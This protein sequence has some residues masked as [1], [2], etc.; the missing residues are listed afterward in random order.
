MDPLDRRVLVLNRLWQPV[1]ICGCRRAVGL[2]FLGHAEVVDVDDG[3]RFST[4]AIDSWIERSRGWRGT[5]V[6]HSVAVSLRS[7]AIIVLASYDRLPKQEI[8]FSRRN[9][10]ERDGYRCQYCGERFEPRDLNLDH[11]VP[12]DKGGGTSWENVVCSCVACNTRKANKLPAEANM[13]PLNE[14]AEPNWRP[15]FSSPSY[16]PFRVEHESWNHFLVTGDRKSA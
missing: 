5:E 14:P 6:I 12:R 11:V 15:L 3:G 9:V 8:R 4:H 13:F 1:N 16:R 10:F 2:L 7:P